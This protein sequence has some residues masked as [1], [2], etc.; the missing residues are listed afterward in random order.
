MRGYRKL[1]MYALAVAVVAFI[2]MSA[3]NAGVME[4]LILAAIGGNALEHIGGAISGEVADRRTHRDRG[5]AGDAG[6]SGS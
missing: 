6:G 2:P 4:T 1:I 3:T 5:S